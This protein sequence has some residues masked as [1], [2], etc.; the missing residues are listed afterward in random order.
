MATSTELRTLMMVLSQSKQ[1]SS[2]PDTPSELTMIPP[3]RSQCSCASAG[4]F[5]Q[6]DRGVA[7]RFGCRVQSSKL[8]SDSSGIEPSWPN[9]SRYCSKCS[10]DWP[11]MWTATLMQSPGR[12]SGMPRPRRVCRSPAYLRLRVP[13][14]AWGRRDSQ[15]GLPAPPL[16]RPSPCAPDQWHVRLPC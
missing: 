10:A 5:S 7:R 2:P 12:Q 6:T 14:P 13:G 16:Q 4:G 9:T 3:S 15:T 11:S 8:C 1:S